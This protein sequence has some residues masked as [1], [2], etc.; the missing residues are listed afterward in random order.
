[1][2]TQIWLIV[3]LQGIS[4]TSDYCH[5]HPPMKNCNLTLFAISGTNTFPALI[6]SA[7]SLQAWFSAGHMF[8]FCVC[9]CLYVHVCVFLCVCV[10]VYHAKRRP[11]RERERESGCWGKWLGLGVTC[12]AMHWWSCETCSNYTPL[13]KKADPLSWAE[14]CVYM[15]PRGCRVSVCT[16]KNRGF[17]MVLLKDWGST[18]DHL[19]LKTPFF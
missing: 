6:P 13:K 1:M 18:H 9:V 14:K 8:F 15:C 16:L 5:E 12:S 2:K 7:W 4:T 3:L 11:E 19:P 10:C 17:K